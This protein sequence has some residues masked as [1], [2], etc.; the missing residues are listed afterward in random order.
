MDLSICAFKKK[1]IIKPSD[2]FR[3]KFLFFEVFLIF[4]TD[5]TIEFAS[6]KDFF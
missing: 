5:W 2:S 3:F 1:L 6:F 4:N